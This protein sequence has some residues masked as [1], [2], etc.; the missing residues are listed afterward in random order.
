MAKKK[1][2]EEP[3]EEPV[4]EPIEEPIEEPA[5]EPPARSWRSVEL[6]MSA[7]NADFFNKC[8]SRQRR[9]KA[10]VYDG[11]HYTVLS[12]YYETTSKKYIIKLEPVT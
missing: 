6:P 1:V 11:L 5:P 8:K 12:A 3:I 4:E 9:G 7:R 10:L 2:I